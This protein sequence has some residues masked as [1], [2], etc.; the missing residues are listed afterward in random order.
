MVGNLKVTQSFVLPATYSSRSAKPTPMSMPPSSWPSTFWGWMTVPGSAAD[1]IRTTLT[2]PVAVST[3]TSAIW[4]EK[5]WTSNE[6]PWPV[7][8]SSGAVSSV[9]RRPT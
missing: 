1:V 3:S 9:V 7:A 2:S 8:G 5:T 4:T 6:G